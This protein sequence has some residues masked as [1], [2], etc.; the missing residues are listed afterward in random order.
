MQKRSFLSYQLLDKINNE[1]MGVNQYYG[2]VKIIYENKSYSEIKFRNICQYHAHEK[3]KKSSHVDTWILCGKTTLRGKKPLNCFL[4][5]LIFYCFKIF[6]FTFY[7]LTP[8]SNGALTPR[9]RV[10]NVGHKQLRAST[11][12]IDN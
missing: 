6:S 11:P 10:R 1:R 5:I 12:I 7:Q 8:T 3:H 2:N 4:P 9:M